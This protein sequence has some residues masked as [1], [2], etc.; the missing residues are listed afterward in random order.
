M[1]IE[2][3]YIKAVIYINKKMIA[4]IIIAAIATTGGLQPIKTSAIENNSVIKEQTQMSKIIEV[5][6]GK[7]YDINEVIKIIENKYLE[8]NED[9]TLK[10]K[11]QLQMKLVKNL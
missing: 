10:I 2:L 8:Q 5:E 9:G 7:V 11:K 1:E 3:N 6:E 4:V